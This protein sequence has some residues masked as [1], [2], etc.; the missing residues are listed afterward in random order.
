[1]TDG[2]GLGSDTLTITVNNVAPVVTITDAQ[3]EIDEGSTFSGSGSFTDPGADTWTATVDYGD[4]SGVQSLALEAGKTFTLSHV[5]ADDGVYTVTVTVTDGDGLGSDTLTITV[6]NMAPLVTADILNQGV[7]YSDPIAEVTITATDVPA[8]VMNASTSYSTDGGATF[9][10]GLPDAMTI[11]GELDLTGDADQVDDGIWV[12]SGVADLAP[13]VYVI[14][15]T[16]A[17]EDG[18]EGWVDITITVIPEDAFA[19]YVGAEF[20]STSSIKTSTAVVELR[21]VI[22][23][24]TAVNQGHDPDAGNI[25]RATV[26]FVDRETGQVIARDVPVYSLGGSLTTGV[27]TYAWTVN[28][29]SQDSVSYQIGIVVNDFY[30]RN[31]TEDDP[32][33]TVSKPVENSI[34]GGGHFINEDS[35][36]LFA[37]TAGLKTNFGFNVKFNKKLTNVQGQVNIIIRQGDR[38]YQIK[39]NAIQSLVV[40]QDSGTAT[41][42]SKANLTDI[43]DPD[44]PISIAGNLSLV[45]T[46][47]DRGQSSTSDSIGITLWNGSDLWYSSRW[48]K[49][50][51][52]EEF[53]IG[54]NL[55]IR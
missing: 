3:T 7:Q 13:G 40:N 46:V 50:K 32:I 17:D 49:T 6:N 39:S 55:V 12:L 2:D 51:T 26:N 14:R 35:G 19:T 24:I 33:V 20:V 31:D 22:E 41:F 23:D 42:I 48:N 45:I 34:T 21:A 5:Y 16:V 25:S 1:V 53:L 9:T 36:G 43:T 10:A 15:V 52:E 11:T 54:G 47:T 8:D 38:V 44:N 28:L 18:G 37:G 29:G 27:A 4:G 30:A